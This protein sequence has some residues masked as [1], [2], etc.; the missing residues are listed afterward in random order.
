MGKKIENPIKEGLISQIYTHAFTEPKTGYQIAKELNYPYINKIYTIIKEYSDLFEI[1]E[2]T[3]GDRTIKLLKSRIEPL[4][5]TIKE[6][7]AEK[8][9]AL[10][11][12]EERIVAK[13]LEEDFRKIIKTILSEKGVNVLDDFFNS[14]ELFK[15]LMHMENIAKQKNKDVAEFYKILMNF[16]IENTPLGKEGLEAYKKIRN[17]PQLINKICNA[18]KAHPYLRI[19][20]NSI[21][22]SMKSI[23]KNQHID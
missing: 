4:L 3:E 10:T 11:N 19:L 2:K 20:Y 15:T 7:L 6:E 17:Y 1:L 23:E 8:K 13:Y 16:S 18:K 21:L 9:I 12:D 22:S 5:A 14:F